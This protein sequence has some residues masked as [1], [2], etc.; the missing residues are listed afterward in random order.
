MTEPKLARPQYGL[1][2]EVLTEDEVALLMFRCMAGTHPKGWREKELVRVC[3]W[4]QEVRIRAAI[5]ES[6]LSGEILAADLKDNEPLLHL[7]EQGFKWAQKLLD[8]ASHERAA[9]IDV[10]QHRVAELEGAYAKAIEDMRKMAEAGARF[11]KALADAKES[12]ERA[13]AD[14]NDAEERL[15]A[16]NKRIADLENQVHQQSIARLASDFPPSSEVEKQEH[17]PAPGSW[18]AQ[19]VAAHGTTIVT[20]V[21]ADTPLSRSEKSKGLGKPAPVAA[22]S[23]LNGKRPGVQSRPRRPGDEPPP[24]PAVPVEKTVEPPPDMTPRRVKG[25]VLPKVF[26]KCGWAKKF[27]RECQMAQ[28]PVRTVMREGTWIVEQI[29]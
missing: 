4:A 7:T 28:I 24:P 13:H 1:R 20:D 17:A 11:D 18:E 26:S 27:E 23:E 5:V 2:E 22:K 16:A 14:A 19:Q 8:K 12:E 21:E 25:I 3:T 29:P 9:R 15:Q 10:L 6:I